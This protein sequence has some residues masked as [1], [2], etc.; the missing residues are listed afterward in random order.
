MYTSSPPREG[1]KAAFTLSKK[2]T[3]HVVKLGM[4]KREL[5]AS[6]NEQGSMQAFLAGRPKGEWYSSLITNPP[7]S[8]FLTST[9]AAAV[10][11]SQLHPSFIRSIF[12][13]LNIIILTCH[14]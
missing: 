4:N 12:I 2:K 5:G 10:S 8:D 6:H 7:V 13:R 9:I 14:M 3:R 11:S 1:A